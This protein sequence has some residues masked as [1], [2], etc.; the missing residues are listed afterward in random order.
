MPASFYGPGAGWEDCASAFSRADAWMS[1]LDAEMPARHHLP[2]H[3]GRAGT[4]DQFPGIRPSRTCARQPGAGP[5]AAHLRH[6]RVHRESW[7]A[8]WTSGAAVPKLY[9]ANRAAAERKAGRDYWYYN[10]GRPAGAALVMDAPPTD[11]RMIG[12]AAFKVGMPVYFYWHARPLAAQP[13]EKTGRAQAERLGGSGDLRFARRQRQGRLGQR[14]GGAAVPGHRALHPAEDRGIAG[15]ISTV[16]LAN[17]RR[18]LQDHLYLTLARQRGHQALVA[19]LVESIVP[20]VF[21]QAPKGPVAFPQDTES[22]ERA[23][24][25]LLQALAGKR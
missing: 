7:P 16:R 8:R 15:P 25:R 4:E 3:G 10:G 14:R 13:P 18:G 5:A 9:D 12:W 6:A 21:N 20:R 22:Y 17:L 1:F 23:R 11:A 2:L 24:L 19:E